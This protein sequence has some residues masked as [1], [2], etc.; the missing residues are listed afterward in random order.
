MPISDAVRGGNNDGIA[1]CRRGVV[2]L[3]CLSSCLD[4][5]AIALILLWRLLG[6]S[7]GL[8]LEARSSSLFTFESVAYCKAVAGSMVTEALSKGPDSFFLSFYVCF[9]VDM[10][11]AFV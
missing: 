6:N 4:S 5:H 9:F 2:S 3:G 7:M 8:I 1:G 11:I 10:H